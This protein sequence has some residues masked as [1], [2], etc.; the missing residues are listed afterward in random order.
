VW[1]AGQ[2]G[3]VDNS[4]AKLRPAH[5]ATVTVKAGEESAPVYGRAYPEP[6]AYDPYQIPV[7]S[8]VPLQ[9]TIGAGQSY[10]LADD[11]IQ[12]DYY[13]A[14]SFNCAHLVDDCTDVVGQ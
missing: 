8:V 7:Q 3:W 11:D 5:G 4:P 9:Y 14:K 10:V 1:F 6:S 2:L 13:Y 12:T